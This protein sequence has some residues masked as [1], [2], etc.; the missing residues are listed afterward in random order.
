MVAGIV[1]LGVVLFAMTPFTRHLA[2]HRQFQ[3]V[4]GSLVF[5]TAKV[6]FAAMPARLVSYRPAMLCQ[7]V[8]RHVRGVVVALFTLASL[9]GVGKARRVVNVDRLMLAVGVRVSVSGFAVVAGY[10]VF[11]VVGSGNA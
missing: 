11:D 4:H 10:V 2:K 1:Q 5:R 7:P 6:R 3:R 8:F 9:L